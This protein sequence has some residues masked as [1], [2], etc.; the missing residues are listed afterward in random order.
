MSGRI[1]MMIG[2][3]ER[4]TTPHQFNGFR[5][6]RCTIPVQN[7]SYEV[8]KSVPV[9]FAPIKPPR[10][11]VGRVQLCGIANIR[12]AEGHTSFAC[13]GFRSSGIHRS[14]AT[15]A[16]MIYGRV[17]CQ[18]NDR[19]LRSQ[20]NAFLSIPIAHDKKPPII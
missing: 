1:R 19:I 3:R 4:E 5:L 10:F 6:F 9:A 18:A 2:D 7:G 14:S 15:C 12:D 17:A 20:A 8:L 16:P 11:A 13:E